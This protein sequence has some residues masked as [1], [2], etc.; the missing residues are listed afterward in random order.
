MS[1]LDFAIMFDVQEGGVIV[2]IDWN[3]D[4]LQPDKSIIVLDESSLALYLW[5]GARQGLVARRTALRQAESLKGHGYTLNKSIIGRNIRVIKEI[6]SR[7]VGR[8]PEETEKWEDLQQVL[9]RKFKVIEDKLITFQIKEAEAVKE[10]VKPIFTEEP[11]VKEEPKETPKAE[12][13]VPKPVLSRPKPEGAPPASTKITAMGQETVKVKESP[14]EAKPSPVKSEEQDLLTKCRIAFVI[15]SI[16]DHYDDLWISKKSDGSIGVEMID[17]PI[18]Q[19]S[20]KE[21]AKLSFTRDSFNGIS[22]K[23]SNAIK[24]SYVDLSKML[25]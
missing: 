25:K 19:F 20:V 15:I 9:N 2:P 3:K 17:G 1:K 8:V 16:L 21:G 12:I 6:D 10:V 14:E 7:K 13:K 4:N 22:T 5:H 18:C 23:I 24:K 11:K